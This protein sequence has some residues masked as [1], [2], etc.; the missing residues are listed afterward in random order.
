MID[1]SKYD[2]ALMLS[3]AFNIDIKAAS[4]SCLMVNE[5]IH[6]QLTKHCDNYTEND[7]HAINK[8]IRN[9]LD[10]NR[11][12]PENICRDRA[13]TVQQCI[14]DMAKQA[15]LQYIRSVYYPKSTLVHI[16]RDMKVDVTGA[17]ACLEGMGAFLSPS[18]KYVLRLMYGEGCTVMQAAEVL[19]VS[20]QEVRTIHR[21][22][23]ASLR[24]EWLALRDALTWGEGLKQ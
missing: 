19:G 24:Q 7:T 2:L 6:F 22:A 16:F 11:Y 9:L 17:E 13:M 21:Q 15:A 4:E 3:K 5:I 18:E 1:D 20:P 10:H 14:I 8:I 12:C 23:F